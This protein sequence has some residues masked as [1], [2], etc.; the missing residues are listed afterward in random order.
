MVF[1][2]SPRRG[3]PKNVTKQIKEKI[4]KMFFFGEEF[5]DTIFFL[6]FLCVFELSSLPGPEKH[7]KIR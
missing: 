5:P 1:S 6:S 2:N 7:P 4:P 3:T